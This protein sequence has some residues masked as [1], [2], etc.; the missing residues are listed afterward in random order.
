M[1]QPYPTHEEFQQIRAYAEKFLV[2]DGILPVLECG[3]CNAETVLR[4]KVEAVPG[5]QYRWVIRQI[6]YLCWQ[7]R[8]SRLYLVWDR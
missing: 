8:C 3:S 4:F 6:W 5:S 2:E 7:K 1:G